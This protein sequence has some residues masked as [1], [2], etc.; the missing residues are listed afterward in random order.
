MCVFSVVKKHNAARE[1]FNKLPADSINIVYK[2]WHAKVRISKDARLV[3]VAC[4]SFFMLSLSWVIGQHSS[5]ACCQTCSKL[6][7]SQDYQLSQ[8]SFFLLVSL[9][10]LYTKNENPCCLCYAERK[11]WINIRLVQLEGGSDVVGIPPLIRAFD[12]LWMMHLHAAHSWTKMSTKWLFFILKMADCMNFFYTDFS[13]HIIGNL[14]IF[15]TGIGYF[16]ISPICMSSFVPCTSLVYCILKLFLVT[17]IFLP[18]NQHVRSAP[19]SVL[20]VQR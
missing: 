13:T 17:M 14:A 20:I 4:Y 9:V 11:E 7:N 15:G 16:I 19:V 8:K 18:I 10:C 5:L 1:V 2:I 12:S 3:V 6:V